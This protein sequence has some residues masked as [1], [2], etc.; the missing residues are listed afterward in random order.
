MAKLP[1]FVDLHD[2]RAIVAGGSAAAAWKAELLS[3][4]GARVVIYADHVG[5]EMQ[6]LLAG[7]PRGGSLHLIDRHWQAGDL[8]DAAIAVLDT[9]DP[10]EARRFRAAA[11]DEGAICSVIDKPAFCDVQ[12]GAIVNRSPVV[13]GISTDGAA[14]VLA[15]AIRRRIETVLPPGLAEWAR[16]AR[17]LRRRLGTL[18]PSPAGRRAF[19][20]RFADLAFTCR[21]PLAPESL[22]PIALRSRHETG[23]SVIL[24][25][26]GP[27]EADLLTLKAVRALQS[28]DVIL[29]DDLVS[30][31]VLELA[32]REA[33]RLLVGRRVGRSGCRRD[34][35]DGLMVQLAR[36]GKRVVRLIAG[37]PVISGRAGAEIAILQS[38]GIPVSVIPGIATAAAFGAPSAHR[39]AHDDA[40]SA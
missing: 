6:A 14:P 25:G 19:W 7:E 5:A 39:Q 20:E 27:G 10:D 2:R 29:F 37:D 13:V 40:Q 15:Q 16:L 34:G 21:P 12:F 3:A 26:A 11:H 32:R 1:L 23:G 30:N 9:D 28:A 22:L 33:K 8:C 4:A 24:V 38:A 17:S 36:Q 18:L 31:D 35:I